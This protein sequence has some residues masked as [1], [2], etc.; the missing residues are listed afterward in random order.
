MAGKEYSLKAVLSATDKISP[1]LKKIDANFGKIGRSFSAL[2]KSS[3]ALAS[4]FALPLTVLGGVG[5]FSLKAAVDKF[6]SLGD[7][8]DKASKRAGVSAQSLQKLRYAAG[9]GGMSAEQMDQA[10]VKLTY[11]MGKAARGENKELAAIFKRLGVSLKDSKGNIRDAADVMRNLAQAVKNNESPAVRLR[12][13]T[14]AVG[15]DLA[16]QLIPV[17]EGGAA[18]LDDMGNEAEKLGIVMNDKMVADSAHLTD[19]MSKFSQVLDG[20][21]A[22]IGASLAPVIETIVKRIQDWVTANKDLITQRLEAIFE[23]ISKAVSEID[24][25]K[26]VDGVFNLIDGFMNFVDSIGGWDTIIKGF[27][28]LIGLTLVG[29]MISLGQSLY[30]VG[31][32]ITAAFGP[33]GWIIGGAIAAGI[34]LWKNWDDISAWFKKTFPDLSKV[35]SKLPEGFSLAWDNACKSIRKL[36]DGL[37]ETWENIKKKLSWEN[38]KGSAREML[39]LSREEAKPQRSAPMISSSEAAAMSRGLPTQKTEV[40]NRLE[41]V[42][43]VPNGTEAQVNKQDSSGGYFSASTQNYPIEDC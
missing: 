2:G 17:L 42:V 7:S 41:V 19:T 38:I 18:G 21:S 30:G 1:A 37:T 26:A 34:A 9:L 36:W 39:G 43:K 3:A 31:A 8:I 6:T 15:D 16:K 14:A 29:N 40:D 5:G 32:A 25:E 11:N 13:L 24:F 27:G 10:L 23:K 35:L 4:K 22:T 20:V 33:W 28:A 12:I